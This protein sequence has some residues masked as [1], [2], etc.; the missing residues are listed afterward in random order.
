MSPLPLRQ[1]RRQR[2]SVSRTRRVA[3]AAALVFAVAAPAAAQTAPV[4]VEHASPTREGNVFDHRDHQPTEAQVD[5]AEGS[6]GINSPSPTTEHQVEEG[7]DKLLRQ[8]DELDQDAT[9]QGRNYPAGS[10]AQPPR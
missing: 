7:V 2:A 9:A 8:T 10:A 5:R 1:S 4:D 6:S 3:T